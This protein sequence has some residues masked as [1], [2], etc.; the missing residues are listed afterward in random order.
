MLAQDHLTLRLIRLK[1]AE[2]WT[3]K[4]KGLCFL[5]LKGGCGR[6]AAGNMTQHLA[7]G[8]VLLLNE[9]LRGKV[10]V[11]S[12]TELVFWSF[13]LCLEHLFPLFSGEEIPLLQRVVDNLKLLKV[14]PAATPLA[15]EC[16]RLL[17]SAPPQFNLAHRGQVLR[18]ASAMLSEEFNTAH[19]QHAGFVRV[20]EH[21]IQVFEKLPADELLTLSVPELASKF[22]CSRRHLNRLFHQHF[23]FSVT[24]FRMEMRLIKAVSL[25]RDPDAKIINVAVQ[26]GF[27]HL[28]LF[29]TCFKRRFGTSPGQWRKSAEQVKAQP[30]G[31]GVGDAFCPLRPM[32]MCPLTGE[33]GSEIPESRNGLRPKSW[34]PAQ[35]CLGTIKIDQPPRGGT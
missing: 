33:T 11:I 27:N 5:F 25:L 32:G 21:M 12:D 16:H 2:E 4:R 8:D 19:G 28:G 23:G 24:A 34:Q 3:H 22:G 20:E 6:C 14:Y 29:N 30:P 17:A 35:S 10:L 9:G 31:A 7:P 13:S 26:C 15:V 18:V 1:P